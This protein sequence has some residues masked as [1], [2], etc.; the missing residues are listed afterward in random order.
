MA[1]EI[2]FLNFFSALP[3]D[4]AL[5]PVVQGLLVTGAEIDKT[6]RTLRA[7]LKGPARPGPAL[8]RLEELVASAYRMQRVELSLAALPEPLPPLKTA[9]APPV[10]APGPPKPALL[11]P[12]PPPP[13]LG[14]GFPRQHRLFPVTGGLQGY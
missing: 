12:P 14:G 5:A 11:P 1:P 7:N 9:G 10:S 8:S 2:P 6:A 13:G 3:A 4:P